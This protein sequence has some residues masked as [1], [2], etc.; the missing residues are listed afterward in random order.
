MSIRVIPCLLLKN[1]GLVKTV[2]FKNEIYVG[3]P[4]NAIR[5]FNDKE[6][7]EL[8]FLDILA[9]KENR[10]P[11]IAY[12][13]NLASECF[14]PFAY[15]G[16]ITTLDQ[17]AELNSIGVEKVIINSAAFLDETFIPKAV[18]RFGT[19]S[20]V[21]SLDFKKDLFGNYNA[22]LSFKEILTKVNQWQVGEVI[23]NCIEKDGVMNGYDEVLIKKASS[24]LD[25]PLVALGGAG[26][27]EHMKSAVSNA[28]A[29]AVAA[30]SFFVFYGPHKAVLINYPSIEQLNV[31]NS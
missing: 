11:N 7:D 10:N 20:I 28:G 2:K 23:I 24:E 27:L 9:S 30:G 14:M 8:V 31:L 3:D 25:M 5:I 17:I 18:E 4:I 16:G 26:T 15:G 13:S 12:I 29:S 6:V 22:Y 1:Q 19:S 21:L